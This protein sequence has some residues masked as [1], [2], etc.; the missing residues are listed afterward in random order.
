MEIFFSVMQ[1]VQFECAMVI[2]PLASFTFR[3]NCGVLFSW[4]HLAFE[5]VETY[6]WKIGLV[7]C[8]WSN[9]NVP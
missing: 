2:H 5:K 6:L 1:M 7:D 9:L 3:V 8:K 4:L